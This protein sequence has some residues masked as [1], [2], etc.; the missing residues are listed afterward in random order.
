[1]QVLSRI[2]HAKAAASAVF[3]GPAAGWEEALA[4]HA[5][6]IVDA[7]DPCNYRC[8]CTVRSGGTPMC[9]GC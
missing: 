3:L 6:H 9:W 4:D 7:T 5:A 2:Q 8:G 1:M